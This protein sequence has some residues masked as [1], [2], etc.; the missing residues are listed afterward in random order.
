M[1]AQAAC[2]E[3]GIDQQQ[4]GRLIDNGKIPAYRVSRL[5]RLRRDDV[6]RAR[7]LVGLPRR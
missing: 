5:T 6:N 1:S 4:L 7:F 2:R 3:L